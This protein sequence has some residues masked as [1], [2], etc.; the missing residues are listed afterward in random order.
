MKKLAYVFLPLLLAATIY[1]PRRPSTPESAV[2]MP[3][4]TESR[5]VSIKPVRWT[6]LG[7]S[8]PINV[9]AGRTAPITL[10]ADIASGWHIYSI[11]QRPGG[12]I[13]LSIRTLDPPDFALRGVIKAPNPERHFDKNFGMETELYSGRAQ[14]TVP[15]GVPGR[16]AA[17]LKR[18][19]LGARYQ[20]CSATLCLPA[21]TDK[22]DATLQVVTR[23]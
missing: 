3:A 14:F 2:P 6:V 16:A 23:K 5:A 20:V 10:Q 4:A 19:Q 8:A 22:L 12:P 1:L 21:R 13:P 11:T 18:I 9:V 17:G 15:V 7:G